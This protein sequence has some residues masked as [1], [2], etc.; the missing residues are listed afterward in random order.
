MLGKK[1]PWAVIPIKQ[2][3]SITGFTVH[4]SK[5]YSSVKV[6]MKRLKPPNSVLETCLLCLK[7]VLTA[8]L[9]LSQLF[10]TQDLEWGKGY[11]SDKKD[12]TEIPCFINLI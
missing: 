2:E 1:I 10:D 9:S 12:A 5:E 4:F 6:T 3:K 11:N 7:P 8:T